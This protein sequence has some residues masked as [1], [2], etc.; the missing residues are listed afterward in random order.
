MRWEVAA[1]SIASIVESPQFRH[2]VTA[3]ILINAIIVGLDT[4]PDVRATY[5]DVLQISD[6]IV[7]TALYL[8][9]SAFLSQRDRVFRR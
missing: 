3:L 9:N 6:R 8:S 4:Y 1:R 5:G 2:A 7:L